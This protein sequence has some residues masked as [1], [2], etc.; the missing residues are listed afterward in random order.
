M[1]KLSE[2]VGAIA[3]GTEQI[4]VTDYRPIP[5]Q[6]NGL[7]QADGRADYLDYR[8]LDG[9]GDEGEVDE[10][11]SLGWLGASD[12][13]LVL[14]IDGLDEGNFG[15]LA[16][17]GEHKMSVRALEGRRAKLLGAR[18]SLRKR[19]AN[20]RVR[21]QIRAAFMRQAKAITAQIIA[22]NKQI[23]MARRAAVASNKARSQV[24]AA[25][26]R[27]TPGSVIAKVDKTIDAVVAAK[28]QQDLVPRAE[29]APA[30][31]ADV[32]IDSASNAVPA[33]AP[34][35]PVDMAV[36]EQQN[37]EDAEVTDNGISEESA[38]DEF[39]SLGQSASLQRAIAK[40]KSN[41]KAT[42][43]GLMSRIIAADAALKKRVKMNLAAKGKV[44]A[45]SP[46][47]A[48]KLAQQAQKSKQPG[49]SVARAVVGSYNTAAKYAKL[50][51]KYKGQAT[52]AM[53]R[54]DK[55]LAAAYTVKALE[56]ARKA[57]ITA[58]KGEKTRLAVGLDRYAK[59]FSAQAGVLR[60]AASRMA[61]G[62][63]AGKSAQLLA[64]AAALEANAK[65]LRTQGANVQAQPDEPKGLP[66]PQRIAEVANK[67]NVR[68][69]FKN[70]AQDRRALIS[71]LGE[72]YD[73]PLAQADDFEGALGYYGAD[74]L[75]RLAAS[76]EFGQYSQ[77]D[78]ILQGLGED[79]GAWYDN[80]PG[81]GK[82]KELLNK[83]KDLG[84]KIDKNIIQPV[85]R[86]TGI[87]K[88][89]AAT[90][91]KVSAPAPS[92][93]AAAAAVDAASAAASSGSSSS[94]SSSA[95]DAASSDTIFGLPKMVVYG[96]GAAVALG[97]VYFFM[98]KQ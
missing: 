91:P 47:A 37:V 23:D 59:V 49:T 34:A 53:R 83:A 1:A 4:A 28:A 56:Y 43:Q 39:G 51:K 20:Q 80:L 36:Q 50:A 24:V 64:Q 14:G 46:T 42:P 5:G 65:K 74:S 55:R 10:L 8:D 11:D 30:F 77:A 58:N 13:D 19:A 82:A 2:V 69:S 48:I 15:V 70:K 54:N 63:N 7:G 98:K 72:A 88:P 17:W 12:D 40:R 94:G 86:A 71:V 60:N 85:A 62:T 27:A 52:L 78:A 41:A 76:I 18:D 84:K 81:A 3:P 32:G 93:A 66:T 68:T 45:S 97:A 33:V 57:G 26:A 6:T 87:K 61:S 89:A 9:L 44:A 31:R 22:V 29:A 79:L 25:M 96:G 90:P 75:G 38:G 92:T 95:A 21:P 35:P 67:F 73:A 16:A